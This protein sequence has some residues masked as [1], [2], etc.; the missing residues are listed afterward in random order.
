VIWG[1]ARD[2]L[3]GELPP[4]VT[5]EEVANL[6]QLQGQMDGRGALVLAHPA[7][8][9]AEKAAVAAWL[10]DG[11]EQNAIVVA[12]VELDETDSVLGRFPFLDDVL[13]RPVTGMRL[14][15]R[16]KHSQD[17][18][19]TRR[20][21][22]QL[23]EKLARRSKDLGELNKIGINLSSQRDID[24]LLTMILDGSR[25]ITSSDAGS[26][27]LVERGKD[28][29]ST[30]D[31]RLRFKLAQNDSVRVAFTEF[32]M[33]LDDT[34]IAGYAANRGVV[35]NVP[36]AYHLPPDSPYQYGR[37]FDER[38]GYR[39]KSVLAVPMHDHRDTVIGVVQL[40]N[41]KHD[42]KAVLKPIEVVEEM[43][44]AF[45]QTDEELVRS[46]ASQAAVALENARLIQDMK[47]L[48][49]S[50]VKASVITIEKRDPVTSGH[51]S[52]VADLTVALAEKVD[53]AT[54][55]VFRDRS[56]SRDQIQEIR[57]ASLLHDFG[58]VA[59]QE[60]YLRKGKKLYRSGR[61]LVDQRFAYILRTLEGEHLRKRIAEMEAGAAPARLTEMD[62]DFARRRKEVADIWRTVR[63]SNEPTILDQKTAGI[64]LDLPNRFYEDIDGKEQ[65]YLTAEEAENLSV[66][67]G[68]LTTFERLK[69]EKHVEETFDFLKVL[70]WTP[71]LRNVPDFAGKHH[72]KLDGSGY[73]RKKIEDGREVQVWSAKDIPIQSRMMTI[74][75]IYD[76][77]TAWNRPYKRAV[78]WEEALDIMTKEEAAR[79]RIDKDLLELFIEAKV[80]EKTM[81]WVSRVGEQPVTETP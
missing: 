36:D 27:Y 78:Y 64:L 61:I 1:K 32:T 46:L 22:S 16:L 18:L 65:P 23:Q 58:K 81:E 24:K 41:K 29:D 14:S 74:A 51:S 80:Y 8:L 47:N 4:G 2:L 28:D 40:I 53:A 69:I 45:T 43:V 72:A 25:E 77:L 38:S 63:A 76:A 9:E 75:D 17:A 52:R 15:L 19:H 66:V 49:E 67:R 73:P 62:A 42:A 34:S 5:T 3:A 21:I 33:P 10:K 20:M 68:T 13:I 60:K 6:A 7:L 54:S 56:F 35:V 31:D 12:V 55:G 57:Y 79:G 59:V 30:D 48:F 70:P 50:F 26:L 37:G 71:E 44:T 11:A 39:T